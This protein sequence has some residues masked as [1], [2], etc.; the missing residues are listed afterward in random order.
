MRCVEYCTRDHVGNPGGRDILPIQGEDCNLYP[1]AKSRIYRTF[2][3]SSLRAEVEY[4]RAAITRSDDRRRKAEKRRDL[5]ES[6]YSMVEKE[7]TKS[8]CARDE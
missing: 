8:K 5:F 6:A 4:M 2:G 1:G 3:R 7:T